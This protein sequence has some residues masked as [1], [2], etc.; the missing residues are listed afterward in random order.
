MTLKD[1]IEHAH[2]QEILA[3]VHL[4]TKLHAAVEMLKEIQWSNCAVYWDDG[5][6]AGACPVCEN[7]KRDGGHADDCELAALISE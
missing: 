7:F 2:E 5:G 6:T 4:R 1:A 3:R